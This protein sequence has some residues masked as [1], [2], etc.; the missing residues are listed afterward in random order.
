MKILLSHFRKPFLS[1]CLAALLAGP[2]AG[3]G[4]GNEDA[5]APVEARPTHDGVE[6]PL[7]AGEHILP[8]ASGDCAVV[9]F[10]PHEERLERYAAFWSKAD[11]SGE[12]RFGLAHGEGDITGTEGG[13]SIHTFML[14]G[15]EINPAEATTTSVSEDGITSW[16]SPT[17]TLH[18]FSGPAFS[19]VGSRRYAIRVGKD[20]SGELELGDLA[21]DWYGTDYLERRTFDDDGREVTMSISAWDVATYC[22]LGAPPEFKGYEKEMKK[23]CKKRGDKL[24]LFRREGPVAEPW[25]SRPITWMK[26]CPVNKILG[27]SDCGKLA[28]EAIGEDAAELEVLLTQGDEAARA[29]ATQEII[30]RFA[31]LEDSV[32]IVPVAEEVTEA[33][34]E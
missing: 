11:W 27:T 32:A 1:I 28:V 30:D 31:P 19:D 18:F 20:P 2:A 21:S 15:L 7:R 3:A 25:A 8:T 24:V 26:S 14:Y 4:A 29:A 33:G 13:W 17:G 10:A 6:L 16:E 23:A 12:C 9:V 5:P 34:A 22:G